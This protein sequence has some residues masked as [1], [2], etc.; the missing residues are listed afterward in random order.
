[1]N[2]NGALDRNM[3]TT[4]KTNALISSIYIDTNCN[5]DLAVVRKVN[6]GVS[7]R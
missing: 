1:M 7:G 6:T 3:L 5:D 2:I 4:F